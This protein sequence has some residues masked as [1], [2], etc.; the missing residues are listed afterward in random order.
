MVYLLISYACVSQIV[1]FFDF[2]KRYKITIN[3]SKPIY[4]QEKYSGLLLLDAEKG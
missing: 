1:I 4:F 3:F 2:G